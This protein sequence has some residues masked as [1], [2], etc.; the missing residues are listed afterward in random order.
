MFNDLGDNSISECPWLSWMPLDQAEGVY[1]SAKSKASPTD[2]L[3]T[4]VKMQ[5]LKL[6]RVG[7]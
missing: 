6:S 4:L 3:K 5:A 7:N 2:D 1:L